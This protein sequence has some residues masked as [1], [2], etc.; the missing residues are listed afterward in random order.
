MR[1]SHVL[2]ITFLNI[3]R[4]RKPFPFLVI[5]P[6]T[7]QSPAEMRCPFPGMQLSRLW[8]ASRNIHVL[9]MIQNY[10]FHSCKSI[11]LSG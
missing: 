10:R 9:E 6:D 8:P 1:K 7:H 3:G 11:D 5:D 4:I 2:S